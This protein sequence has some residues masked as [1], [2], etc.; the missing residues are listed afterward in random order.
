MVGRVKARLESNPLPARDNWRFKQN[1]VST[2]TQGEKKK[3]QWPYKRMSQTFLCVS[4]SLRQRHGWQ[5]PATGSGALNTTFLRATHAGIS[6]FERGHHYHR[7]PY[8]NWPQAKL[9]RRNTAP[10]LQQKIWIKG[11][12]SM[13]PPIRA[14]LSLPHSQSLPSGS[15]LKPLILIHQKADRTKT[16]IM[17]S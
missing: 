16:T 8:H 14:R 3:K 17:E 5:W 4:R 1:L 6:P 13:V 12:L 9:R 15:F 11:L 7:Y 2:R 10:P